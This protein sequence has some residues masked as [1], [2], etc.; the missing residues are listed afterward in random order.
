MS[1]MR[2][3]GQGR[4][5]HY[6]RSAISPGNSISA[7]LEQGME[8]SRVLVLCMSANA[9][10]SVWRQLEAGTFRFPCN[11]SALKVAGTLYG[12]RGEPN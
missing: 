6:V 9:L 10:G 7:E 5:R 2:T 8:H 4:T 11:P 3:V 12:W 1:K